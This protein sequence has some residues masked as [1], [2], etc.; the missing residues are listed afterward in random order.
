MGNHHDSIALDW[1]RGEIQETL[2]R[3]Q[4]ALEGFVENRDDTAR[5]R[6][7]LNY[8]HQVHGT[9]QMVELFGAALLTEEMEKLTQA[10]LNESVASVDD[11]IEVLMEAILQLPQ[12][13]E[14][15]GSSRD[16]FP[17]VLLPLL[18][19]LRAARGESLLSDTSLFKPDLTQAQ[20]PA[21]A[22]ASQ[23][24]QDPNVLG[25][26]RKLRQMYQFA[27]AGVVREEDLPSQF[28]YLQ[29][30]IQRL[31]KLCQNTPREQLWLAAGAFVESAQSGDNP[32]NTAVKS[33]LRNLD[34]EL[35]RLTDEHA[36][37]LQQPVPQAL[38]K[39]LLYYVARARDL[40]TPYATRLRAD[41]K[42]DEALP[43]EDDVS[44]ARSRVSGPGREAIHSVVSALNE[45]LAKLKDQ[46]DLFVRAEYRTNEE[47]EELLPGLHQI[48]NTIAILGLAE[49]RQMVT[50]QLDTVTRLVNQS[51]PA[52]DD[53]LMDIAGALLYVE[54]RLAKLDSD[55]ADEPEEE[56]ES[57][58]RPRM[59][60]LEF[61]DASHALLRESRTTVEQIKTA[62]V[63]FLASQWDQREI[64]DVPSQI[65]SIC[66]ALR[67]IPMDRV[68]DILDAAKNY[69][70]QVLFNETL[71]PE[72]EQMESL[73]DAIS[74]VEYYL[75][76][77]ADGANNETI[78]EVAEDS[79]KLLGFPPGEEPTWQETSVSNT[80]ATPAEAPVVANDAPQSV[81]NEDELID[82][83]ILEIFVEEATEVLETIHDFFPRLYQNHD[84]REAL[85]EV[86]RAFHTL[87]GSGRMVNAHSLGELAW[88][89]ENMLNRVI[90]QTVKPTDAL[91]NLVSQVNDRIPQLIEEFRNGN[92]NGDVAD[93]MQ[94]AEALA[95]T[96]KVA[97]AP[98]Q[99]EEP[100]EPE[101][102]ET[103][104]IDTLEAE[105]PAPAQVEAMPAPAE[106]VATGNDYDDLIDDDILEI[107]VEEAGEVLDT[108]RE[109]LPM[110]VRQHDDRSALAEVRRAFHTLKGSGRMVGA[111]VVGELAWSVENMLNRVIDGSILMNE[112]IVTLLQDVTAILPSLVKDFEERRPASQDT[113]PYESRANALAS[114]DI[115]DTKAMPAAD[116]TDE[117]EEPE[118]LIDVD[119]DAG[120]DSE[121]NVDS[122]LLG[123]FESETETHLQTLQAFLANA[124]EKSAVAYTDDVSRAL[125]TL[126]GSAHTASITPIANVIT[127]LERYVKDARAAGL[128]ADREGLEL[129]SEA[130]Q[131][132]TQGLAQ[133]RQTPQASLEGT[134]EYLTRLEEL[135]N[136]SLGRADDVEADVT[137]ALPDAHLV[138]LFLSEGLD[139]LLD[140]DRI[141]DQWA[142]APEDSSP[143]DILGHE[144][145]QLAI[146]AAQAGLTDVSDLARILADVYSGPK[147]A[148][149]S[150]N[151]E[152]IQTIRD[153]HEHLINM[154]DQVA[155][156][157]ATRSDALLND[158]LKG[159]LE[160]HA[161]ADPVTENEQP[162]DVFNDE[163]GNELEEIDL[164]FE[165]ELAEPEPEAEELPQLMEVDEDDQELADIF[166]EEA[167]ELIDNTAESLHRWNENP[168]NTELLQSLQRDLHTL[169]GGARLSELAAIGDLAHELETLF[170]GLSDHR[171]LVDDS[172]ADLLFRSHDR[173]AS[174]IEALEQSQPPR[175]APDLISE[176]QIYMGGSGESLPV[177]ETAEL[178]SVT[179][180]LV[181]LTDF[182]PAPAE[183]A[184][185]PEPEEAIRFEE[186]PS[187][188]EPVLVEESTMAEL[189]PE[190]AEIFLEEAGE[191]IDTTA[192]QLHQWQENPNQ[193]ELVK[194]LQRELHTLK[195]GARMAE[196]AAVAD[197]A[198][199]METLFE[200][201]VEGRIPAT[202]ERTELALRAHDQLAALVESIADSGRCPT[203]PALVQELRHA[204]EDSAAAQP[205]EPEFELPTP[206][207]EADST[208][209]DIEL[210]G[211]EMSELEQD[212]H[213]LLTPTDEI[214]IVEP[215]QPVHDLAALDPELVGIFLEEAYDLINSTGSSLHAWSEQPDNRDIATELQREV[216]TLK[217]GARMA[218][219][220]AI[221]DLTH[222][223]EDL[224]EKVAE[225]QIAA[226][227]QMIDLLFACHD[228]LAQMVEQV[229]TQ[230]PCPPAE[231]L[232]AE[233]TAILTGDQAANAGETIVVDAQPADGAETE[234][235]AEEPASAAPTDD[236]MG[237]FL[238]EGLEIHAAI[239]DCLDQWKSAPE[240]LTGIT[241]LQQ[242]IHTLK[243]G[244]RLAGADSFADLAD[245]WESLLDSV[246]RGSGVQAT[247]L[248][249]SE[250]AV[251]E[252][253]KMLNA[254]E[255]GQKPIPAPALL[256]DIA[257][258]EASA[259]EAEGTAEAA[260]PVD[261]EVIEIFLEEAG[262]LSDQLEH[263]LADWQKDP[264]NHHFNQEAQ[265]VLH[266]L[267]G[268]AR[269]AQLK[270]LGDQSHALETRLIDLG[271]NQPDAEAWQAIT[272][273]YDAIVA[274]VAEVKRQFEAGAEAPEAAAP[275]KAPDITTEEP[276]AA[277]TPA[278]PELPVA[279]PSPE[280][281]DATPAPVVQAEVKAT[282]QPA[283]KAAPSPRTGT[284]ESI[285]V[286]APLLDELVNLA[287]ETSIT[288]G[289][290][291]Q[292]TSDFGYTLEEMAATIERLREQL[293]RMDIE[294]EAQILF[295]AEREHGPDYGEDFDPLEMD[296]YSSIQQLSRALG[297]SS[298][299]LADLRETLA[300]RIRDT[301]TL[302]V[303]QSR[304][305]T[306][307]QEGLM[308]TR[309][310]PFASMVPRL[311]RIVRQISGE[312]GKKVE[313]DVR[314]AEG[315]MDRNILERMIAPL[316]HMLRNAL[317]HGIEMPEDRKA[318]GKPETGEIT[319]SLTREGGDVVLRMM[320]DGKGIPVPVIRDKAIRQGMLREDEELSDR[321]ILQFIL[322]PGFSTAQKVTQISGRGVGMD[323]VG[324]EIKQLGG[325]L[326]IDSA[327]GRGSTFTVRLPFTVSVNRALMVTTGEDFYAIPLNTIEGIVR[328][329]T[330][331]LEEYYKPDAPMYEYA[332]QQYRLQYLGN[333]LHSEHQ[334]KLQGQA[335]PLPVILVRGAEQPMALQVD[336]LLG[337]R[338]IVV[339][340][341]GPQFS[342]VRGVSG[343]TILGDGNVVV[344]LDLPAM[345]RSDILSERQ[346]Q[347]R[348]LEGGQES[349]RREQRPTI[350]MVV[351]DSVTVRKVT[352]R[353]LERN[354]MEVVTAKDG[355]DAVA[356]LQDHRP[357]IILLDIEMPRM[358]GF[359]VASFVR[360]DDTLRDTPICM[361]TSRTG[362]KHRERA[363][364]IGVNEYLGKPFQEAELL[365]T[366]ERLTGDQ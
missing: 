160:S 195:G 1:V 231:E 258:A 270:I 194:E 274:Q 230:K 64:Q 331:E 349:A 120:A 219:V 216:H 314:N 203:V 17:L 237:V 30:V 57:G 133:L 173:L 288:R 290:L 66:G 152:A 300:E 291:E 180:E 191:I 247:V 49:A 59:G 13:L 157:L 11:A 352:S 225:G 218:G 115:P 56:L 73:A 297:E 281:T 364:S 215:E 181:E 131:F 236:L 88:S 186:A 169:K 338:E 310:I 69:I 122:V 58:E 171:L 359:E 275:A 137:E 24:L 92:A 116:E 168:S 78:L 164:S 340:S 284:Q 141:L 109:Y 213:E 271:G 151:A 366:I 129:I 346:R 316:E 126:K 2:I 86:R 7:C 33:I 353:L 82:D 228:R 335:L 61:S 360:H 74:S 337:S 187:A 328:V 117:A 283:K 357:D 5:L 260:E 277:I 130:C 293:R 28:D 226:T 6:F 244:A 15:L 234:L 91:F 106:P 47:L 153:G 145:N 20:K 348:L 55:R 199:E 170:E 200:R 4:Q 269:L 304:I 351:D 210:D 89:V 103:D 336:S 220:A 104:N 114:G 139:I 309:M 107:F 242:E 161:A 198:H 278:V 32:V 83:E 188:E 361:I 354:G 172:L 264:G 287:G 41:Y 65:H 35:R 267:K 201:I 322:Q 113:A 254:L 72:W 190:L 257:A 108:I 224:F 34:T 90:E 121:D 350:V 112:N 79:L 280:P 119:F 25:H 326:D 263:L 97:A 311:R 362:Q 80:E 81:E 140:A 245:H 204:A 37:I 266:T 193:P 307:L 155:A 27:L 211:L 99:P 84:D 26:I 286:S 71:T 21:P 197:I 10:V 235:P 182:E 123:I 183:P 205:A 343:A 292:Q 148:M 101:T 39:H 261:P 276:V 217:G 54:G 347:A 135:A 163:F 22:N 38:F 189:D 282:P 202:T 303:Q 144:L 345:I 253:Q 315:E 298:S 45:E 332:G 330:Y 265:R 75:E 85:T 51:E 43:S 327:L 96:S 344:I 18:N 3:G 302:L 154:M 128:K 136:R 233:V 146:G 232:V 125:H 227:P 358:D 165:L 313:F 179:E 147:Q 299:D 222:V 87:K 363:L 100:E 16:D 50:E 134:D 184:V 62:L 48:A 185:E 279:E 14:H 174:M 356:Q 142:Q 118:Y 138:Q 296:R 127:P 243:G 95:T 255:E 240:E 318:A 295:R 162:A 285:R 262:E 251:D 8:L 149:G 207:V 52:D 223:L 70:T 175:P 40:N 36:N 323:V 289:R 192:E 268:G 294:T 77:L 212:I 98:E 248:A 365:A 305:N 42:L 301:E 156:G 176:I 102:A 196:I 306:E 320:D 63:N 334:P 177:E 124:G 93:L 110:L 259:Q 272:N 178:P 44:E 150:L 143:L 167:R 29:K 132:L 208:T 53:I 339:K 23:R 341:L 249:L 319:L 221:G 238:D 308:K 273:D 159:L 94:Q 209:L 67:L 333:L 166:L 329:S 60:S 252:L 241:Q 105:V 31:I 46:L 250:R 312:L 12:Y 206:V 68:A 214:P 342:S 355:L 229:A 324:S 19:D 239:T 111:L 9:L 256:A 76:Q 325:S 246:V 317:D 321:E 158:A